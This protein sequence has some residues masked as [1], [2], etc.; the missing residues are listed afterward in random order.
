MNQIN[1]SKIKV[2]FDVS[3]LHSG[4]KV[5]GIG[6]YTM[7]LL[8]QLKNIPEIELQEFIDI[9]DVRNADIVHH[10]YFD[11]FTRSLLKASKF[12]TVV[13]IHDVIPLIF[14][15]HYPVGIKG[16]LN[17][18]LQRL[19]LKKVSAII[20]DSES[21]KKDITK[22]L[23]V[24]SKKVFPVNLS[25]SDQFSVIKDINI[26]NSVRDKY[27]L[28][29]NFALYTGNINWNKNLLNMSQACL[30]AGVDLVLVGGG[31]NN[32]ENLNHPELKSFKL[33][34]DK[35]KNNSHIKIV[36]FVDLRELVAMINLAK[37]TLL[38]SFYEGFGLP[39]LESQACGTPVITSNTSS[40]PEVAGKGAILVDPENVQSIVKAIETIYWDKGEQE[41]LVKNGFENLKRF[42]WRKTAEATVEIYKIIQKG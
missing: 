38:T 28:P 10:P 6:S 32:Q 29:E 17:L 20:T 30:D 33:F 34:F 4:H 37:V 21:S 16:R 13:T 7:N 35:Y 41:K 8:T 3:P 26:L 5:R 12:P 24:D 15:Q 11:L 14:P 2:A 31:F 22:I 27:N 19:A 39:I 25:V 23:G 36:G 42:S 9:R 40:M 1:S 18:F